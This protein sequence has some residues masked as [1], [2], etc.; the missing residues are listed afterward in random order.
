MKLKFY[1]QTIKWMHSEITFVGG[2]LSNG[3]GR[4]YQVDGL[5]R[6]VMLNERL[7]LCR[8]W[9]TVGNQKLDVFKFFVLDEETL[10]NFKQEDVQLVGMNIHGKFCFESKFA[11]GLVKETRMDSIPKMDL[12]GKFDGRE[13]NNQ[14]PKGLGI[15]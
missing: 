5:K 10:K 15:N 13:T 6:S 9:E 4:N 1:Y 2:Y 7:F 12:T 14:S 8:I 3:H 11:E